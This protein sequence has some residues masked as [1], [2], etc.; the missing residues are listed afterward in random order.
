MT[1]P[2]ATTAT[3]TTRV[4][5]TLHVTTLVQGVDFT[6][7]NQQRFLDSF[8]IQVSADHVTGTFM[9]LSSTS[10]DTLVTV[11]AH[12]NDVDASQVANSQ[13]SQSDFS[14]QFETAL[15]TDTG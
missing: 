4:V 8:A 3:T 6:I 14:T 7:I 1:T 2:A 12:F 11:T 5:A 13:L 10:M 15:K 9:S